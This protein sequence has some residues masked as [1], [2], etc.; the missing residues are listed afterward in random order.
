MLRTRF[1][2]IAWWALLYLVV[3]QHP[4]QAQIAD[5]NQKMEPKVM[6]DLRQNGKTSFFVVMGAQADVSHAVPIL[7][8]SIRRASS[9]LLF[10]GNGRAYPKT[11]S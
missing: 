10:E 4:V 5:V 8:W 9:N 2:L 6:T 11:H 7:E 3:S 1:K